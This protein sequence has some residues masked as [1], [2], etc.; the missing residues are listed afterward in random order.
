MIFI[1]TVHNTSIDS[2]I[3]SPTLAPVTKHISE[4]DLVPSSVTRPL[5]LP[6]T[7]NPLDLTKPHPILETIL[8]KLLPLN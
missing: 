4:L 1:D 5:T 7:R 2:F 8:V 6:V 3:H